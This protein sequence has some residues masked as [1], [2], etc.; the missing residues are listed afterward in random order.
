MFIVYILRSY[1]GF[2]AQQVVVGKCGVFFIFEKRVFNGP[3]LMAN[4]DSSGQNAYG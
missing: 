4:S 2:S 3:I 1:S